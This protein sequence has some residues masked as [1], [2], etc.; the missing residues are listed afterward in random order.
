MARTRSYV[1]NLSP[2]FQGL[3]DEGGYF[4]VT[5]TQ[6]GIA[7]GA[8]PTAFSDTN[9]FVSIYNKDSAK[10]IY[11]DFL[12]LIATAAGTAGTSLQAAAQIDLLTD[13]YTSGGTD[14]TGSIVNPNGNAPNVSI[15]KFRAGN[16]TAAA[17]SNAARLV[18]GNRWLSGAIPVPGD[19][20]TL[21]FGGIDAPS[22]VGI[23]TIKKVLINVPKIVIPPLGSALVH[24][25][26]PSQS[27][28]SSY[29]AEAGWVEK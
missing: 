7:T 23:S 1:E 10:S 22:F 15:A 29:L 16:I 13:R 20:Y 8:T 11:L 18:V 2:D 21:K 9:P 25:W 12:T 5:S 19:E 27:A 4:C 6:T 28:A 17:K 14:L 3:A 26:L 24:L